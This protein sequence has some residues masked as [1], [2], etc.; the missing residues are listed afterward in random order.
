M[1]VALLQVA[2]F[3]VGLPQFGSLPPLQIYFDFFPAVEN[4]GSSHPFT[5]SHFTCVP[6]V[7]SLPPPLSNNKTIIRLMRELHHHHRST[8]DASVR[9]T[10]K[11]LLHHPRGWWSYRALP[12]PSG[13]A[14]HGFPHGVLQPLSFQNSHPGYLEESV[15]IPIVRAGKS[16]EQGCSYHPISLLCPASKDSKRLLLPTIVEALG[17]LPSHFC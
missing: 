7:F 1:W 12:L 6:E 14:Q 2:Q 3:L 10:G 4:E 11:G 16:R 8:W 5:P 13:G 15:I 9:Q 17:T